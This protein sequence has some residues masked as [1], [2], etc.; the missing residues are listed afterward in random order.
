VALFCPAGVWAQS[1]SFSRSFNPTTVP[2]GGTSTLT[3]TIANTDGVDFT[4][5]SF[6]STPLG[7][8]QVAG[9]ANVMNSCYGGVTANAG[10]GWI[11]LSSGSVA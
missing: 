9:P 2:L 10:D 1:D 7:G 6:T 11:S 5:M 8:L 4:A 3:F